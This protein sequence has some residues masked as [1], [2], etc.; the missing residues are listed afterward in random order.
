MIFVSV[1][2]HPQP[3]TR[4]LSEVVRL[5]ENITIKEEVII[6]RGT[7]PFTHS[8]IK[9]QSFY[10]IEEFEKL[11]AKCDLFIT[12]AGEGNIGTAMKLGKKCIIVPR[13]AR[14]GEHTNDHQLELAQA[15]QENGFGMVVQDV[16]QLGNAI[17]T[18]EQS[19]STVSFTMHGHIPQTLH[20]IAQQHHI[21]PMLPFSPSRTKEKIPKTA[22]IIV[23]TLNGGE[24][25][26]RAVNGM[27]KQ[28]FDGKYDIVVVDDGSFDG[29][30][31]Q[32]LKENF[33]TNKK[34][35][36]VFLPRSGV[37]KARNAGIKN[38]TGEVVINLD[39]DCIPE[40]DW[41]Q[42]MVNG[43]DSQKIGVV[44]AYGHYGGT[45][46]GFRKSILDHLQGYDEDYFYY[47]EDTDLSFRIMELGYEFKRVNGARYREDRTLV[48]P[49]GINKI[50]HYTIQRYK[51]H[52][53]DVLLHKKHPTPLCEEML[54]VHFHHF[55]NPVE[56]F[57]VATGLWNGSKEM[58]VSSP[59]GMTFFKP[60]GI[61]GLLL[62][63][64]VGM[65]YAIGMKLARLAGSIK[66]GH[67][68]I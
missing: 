19:D 16:A 42:T 22:T 57:K 41:L 30:T 40:K 12:H 3:F 8:K 33:S 49:K 4:L 32:L 21:V 47:R 67:L 46:T 18:L 60:R 48:V 39:H 35:K 24:P 10:S 23:A 2:T 43:F 62:T 11:L 9:S 25:L 63:I 7:T 5:V 6:Q 28:E 27:L 66:H 58:E 26:I 14:V 52:M 29:K 38:S 17:R 64:G 44:S 34:I 13:L 1:G 31:P 15:S 53:N 54:H 65:T 45:S 51:Y 68:L 36:L 50:I 61:A 59:R 20:R 55:V 56:D 37:C